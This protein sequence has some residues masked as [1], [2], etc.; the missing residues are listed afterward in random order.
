[1]TRVFNINTKPS[2]DMI[3]EAKKR[4]PYLFLNDT[5]NKPKA[6]NI[7][8][9]TYPQ[10]SNPLFSKNFNAR[11]YAAQQDERSV[12]NKY[13]NLWKGNRQPED[14]QDAFN[15]YNNLWNM[16][17]EIVAKYA[18]WDDDKSYDFKLNNE[19][20]IITPRY[21]QVGDKMLPRNLN[22]PM[23]SNLPTEI[24]VTVLKVMIEVET[25]TLNIK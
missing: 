9:R 10:T 17:A 21:V 13:G 16:I 12:L 20:C 25:F 8:V 4:F 2:A 3:A 22:I 15:T 14:L 24:K 6:K 19:N 7:N 5:E 18:K 11:D 1:M 23:F